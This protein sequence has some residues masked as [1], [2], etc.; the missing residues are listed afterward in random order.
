[1]KYPMFR[2]GMTDANQTEVHKRVQEPGAAGNAIAGH[3]RPRLTTDPMKFVTNRGTPG[4]TSD[5]AIRKYTGAH[6]SDPKKLHTK[7]MC[8]F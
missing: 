3:P 1:M 6:C 2:K 4:A 5:P 8:L 7:R